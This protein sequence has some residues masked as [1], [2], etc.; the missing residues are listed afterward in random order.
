MTKRKKSLPK[1]K[2]DVRCSRVLNSDS[3]RKWRPSQ[4]K[5]PP[6][7]RFLEIAPK[8]RVDRASIMTPPQNEWISPKLTK[9]PSGASLLQQNHVLTNLE[10]KQFNDLCL[11]ISIGVRLSINKYDHCEL[12]HVDD[13]DLLIREHVFRFTENGRFDINLGV[14]HKSPFNFVFTDYCPFLFRV[15]R[16]RYGHECDDYMKSLCGKGKGTHRLA[17]MLSEGKSSASFLISKDSKYI[18]KSLTKAEFQYLQTILCDYYEVSIF[19]PLTLL[20]IY[21]NFILLL[22]Y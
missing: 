22:L 19:I 4:G 12:L 7:S 20:I 3:L 14:T 17:S 10:H 6:V 18:I 8:C 9:Q 21:I 1:S 13:D 11:M 16:R 2:S 15:I 5:R